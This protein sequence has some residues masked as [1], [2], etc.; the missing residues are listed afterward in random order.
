[1]TNVINKYPSIQEIKLKDKDHYYDL[2][3]I[4]SKDPDIIPLFIKDN[5]NDL[6]VV[7]ADKEETLENLEPGWKLV[8]IGKPFDVETVKNE[9]NGGKTNL[10]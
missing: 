8:Y 1:M 6:F 2:I 9:T 7:K 4:S 5:D 10:N 3:E